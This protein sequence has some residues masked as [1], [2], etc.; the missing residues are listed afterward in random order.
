MGLGNLF[1]GAKVLFGS[2]VLVGTQA[3]GN[4]YEIIR[5]IL[6]PAYYSHS[7]PPATPWRCTD[8]RLIESSSPLPRD[9]RALIY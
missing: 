8:I 4:Y 2:A 5:I 9:P 3:G 7:D 1:S 6:C